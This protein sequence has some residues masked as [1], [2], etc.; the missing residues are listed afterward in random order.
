LGDK[1]LGEKHLV[2]VVYKNKNTKQTKTKQ[3]KKTI[4]LFIPILFSLFNTNSQLVKKTQYYTFSKK[5][6]SHFVFHAIITSATKSQIKY[7]LASPRVHNT[8]QKSYLFSTIYI[9][10]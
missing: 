9:D 8:N 3:N 10:N 1:T 6:G 4:S 5:D 7:F 2:I